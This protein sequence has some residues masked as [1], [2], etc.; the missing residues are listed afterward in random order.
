MAEHLKLKGKSRPTRRVWIPKP[1]T[2]EKRPLGI[3]TMY[4]RALQALVKLALE[5]EWEA[6]F[7][8]NSYGFRPGRSCHDAIQQIYAEL[9]GTTKYILDADIAKCFDK[10]NHEE[11]LKKIDTY[12]S[13]RKQIKAWLKSGVMDNGI[14]EETEAGTPQGGV[15]SPLLANIALHGMEKFINGCTNI[16]TKQD[17]PH[18]IRYADDLVV[19]HKNIKVIQKC[20]EALTQWL[21]PMGLELKPSKTR[22]C[23]SL[24]QFNEEQAGFDFLGFNIRQ[25]PRGKTRSMKDGHGKLLGFTL[26]IKPS[27][28]KVATHLDKLKKIVKAHKASPQSALIKELNPIIKGWCNYYSTVVSKEIFSHCD[29]KLREKLRSWANRR[30]TNK[31][32]LAIKGKYW[33]KSVFKTKNGYELFKHSDTPIKRFVK[34]QNVRSPY[35]GDWVYWSS[36]MGKDPMVPNKVATLLKK[37]KGKCTI[38]GSYFTTTD[39]MEVDHITPKSKG[40][41]SS[42]ENLQLLHRHCHDSKTAEDLKVEG[43]TND[44]GYPVEERSEV[45]VSRS[46]LKTS[47]SG[48]ASA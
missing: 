8:P 47:R 32:K 4:D 14:F 31:A 35:D 2:E 1:K 9:K 26:T 39:L 42:R 7:E 28:E 24:E 10:I 17:Q 45:K 20:Q 23:H 12:P 37:Q 29:H 46:V 48:D 41:K 16:V 25:Y 11:L 27:K 40:G 33:E 43:C 30:H 13:L 3:P 44:N 21:K 18:L 19:M 15:I 34:V 22:I 38:C 6:K 5:P 36:R